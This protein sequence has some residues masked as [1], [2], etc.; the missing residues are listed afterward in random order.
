MARL[1]A[2][3][4]QV[5]TKARTPTRRAVQQRP[6]SG[7]VCRPSSPDANEIDNPEGELPSHKGDARGCDP[8]GSDH[9]DVETSCT[10]KQILAVTSATKR[11]STERSTPPGCS[12]VISSVRP[13][14][15]HERVR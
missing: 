14:F 6:A 3:P 11:A 1:G 7:S 8:R 9:L 5:K 4:H 13:P 10:S 12:L 15:H 2:A